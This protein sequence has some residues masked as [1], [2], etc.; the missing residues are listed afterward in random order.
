MNKPFFTK[1]N[2]IICFSWSL[3][4]VI[5][6]CFI[7]AANLLKDDSLQK[8][9]GHIVIFYVAGSCVLSGI[10][11]YITKKEKKH[12]KISKIN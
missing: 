6:L 1:K 11:A 10:V 8:I 3:V 7:F 9:V 12:E 4:G 2:L 5:L